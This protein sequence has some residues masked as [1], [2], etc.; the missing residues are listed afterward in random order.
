[1]PAKVIKGSELS[2]TIRAELKKE[3]EQF[4]QAGVRPGLAVL[5]VGDDPASLMS[6]AKK[7]LAP[8]LAYIQK[9]IDCRHRPDRRSFSSDRELNRKTEIHGILV[10]LPLPSHIS[11]KAVIDAIAPEKMWTDFIRSTSAT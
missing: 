8:I 10:Q 3:V 2:K 7:K 5:L 4:T 9:C 11:E 6:G 1:M